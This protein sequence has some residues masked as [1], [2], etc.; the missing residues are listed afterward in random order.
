MFLMTYCAF[1]IKKVQSKGRKTG[2]LFH[3]RSLFT[4]SFF[5]WYYLFTAIKFREMVISD[6][7]TKGVV[8]G[9]SF[10]GYWVFF[11]EILY[12]EGGRRKFPNEKKIVICGVLG[13]YGILPNFVRT[14]RFFGPWKCD[15]SLKRFFKRPQIFLFFLFFPRKPQIFVVICGLFF[16]CF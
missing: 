9:S 15:Y 16:I 12:W 11:F 7:P 5:H 3:R 8:S 14:P 6:S 2:S 4:F 10:H 1:L 13:E